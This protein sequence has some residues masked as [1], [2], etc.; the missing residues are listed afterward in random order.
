MSD[1]TEEEVQEAVAEVWSDVQELAST[2]EGVSMMMEAQ[3]AY[4]E[5][6]E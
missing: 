1:P 2:P 4:P 6:E 5:H 3:A